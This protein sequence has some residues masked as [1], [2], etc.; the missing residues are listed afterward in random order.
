MGHILSHPVTSKFVT[1][2]G[3]SR[4]KCGSSEMQGY[5]INMEDTHSIQL[6][7]NDSTHKNVAFFGVYDGHSGSQAS[8]FCSNQLHNRIAQLTDPMNIQLVKSAVIQADADFMAN[9]E[10]RTHGNYYSN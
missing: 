5:R 1:R 2:T 7:L 9:E 6:S 10:V 8:L 4:Y 3:T